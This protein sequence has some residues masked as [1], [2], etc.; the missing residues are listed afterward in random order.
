MS[1]SSTAFVLL[2]LIFRPASGQDF[3]YV[4]ES[5]WSVSGGAVAAAAFS[6]DGEWLAVGTGRSCAIF[7]LD[8]LPRVVPRGELSGPRKDVLGVA[9][10]PGGEM[11]A[12]VDA[13]GALYLY[14]T[15]PRRPA[16]EVAKAHSGKAQ[17]VGFTRDGK[18]VLTGGQDGKV[19]AW[20]PSGTFFAEM[21]KGGGHDKGGVVMVGGV[22]PGRNAIS[23][24]RDQRVILWNVDTQSAVRSAAVDR[25]VMSA[26]VS[27]NGKVLAL[28][29]QLLRGNLFRSSTF[30]NAHE[31]RATDTVRLIDAEKGTTLRDLEG[32]SQELTAVSVS[33]DG[34][35]VAS[36]GSGATVSVWSAATGKL[37]T[38]IPFDHRATALAFS[39]DG[40]WLAA[41]TRSGEMSLYRLEGIEAPAPPPPEQ[42]PIVIVITEP[43][44]VIIRSGADQDAAPA[45]IETSSLRVAGRI[46]TPAPIKSLEVDGREITSLIAT[47]EN[48][49]TFK[50]DVPLPSPGRKQV[51]V[52]VENHAGQT[53]HESFIVERI[54]EVRPPEVGEG[55]RIALIVGVS[56]YADSSIDLEYAA[57]DAQALT[58]LL[59]SPA[60]GPAAFRRDDVRLLVDREATVANVNIGLRQFLQK[61]REN[62]FVVVF[63]AG[64]GMPDPDRPQDLYLMAHDSSPADVAGTG[65]LMRHFRE[66][67]A[68][69]KARDVLVVTDSCHSA[70]VAAPPGARAVL[71]VNPIHQAF[72]DKMHHT[73]GGMAIFTASEAAQKSFENEIWRLEVGGKKWSGHGVFTYFLMK[74]LLGEADAD[75]DRIVT[76]GEVME[77]VREKVRDETSMRQIPAI[78]ATSFDRDLPL[79]VVESR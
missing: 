59:T 32:S 47:G 40:R 52:V 73:S 56:K 45:R 74:G 11:L 10:A 37:V 63:F 70:G 46:K 33:P 76:L 2:L 51:A 4:L 50:A 12:L 18:Y 24:G 29:L 68:Q 9:V 41:A 64:H 19:K 30:A 34:R 1:K 3:G 7:D 31:T 57:N 5:Q 25:D 6:P 16:A 35:F 49:Y 14:D 78:G 72:L 48:D 13:A 79:V 39:P 61:A 42:S 75:T 54:E 28:G 17:A 36:G 71:E 21:S 60:L 20:T 38:T 67:V 69:I 62:D 22:A 53:A 44:V 27:H 15:S 65:L 23:V 77:Y 66:A 8:D 26:A 55:R 58:E 43:S